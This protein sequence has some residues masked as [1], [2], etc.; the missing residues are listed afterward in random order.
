MCIWVFLWFIENIKLFEQD[1][2]M[3]EVVWKIYFVFL[4][5]NYYYRNDFLLR[6]QSVNQFF[7][8]LVI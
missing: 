5:L 1:F 2:C 6:C 7:N 4:C 3:F 8:R